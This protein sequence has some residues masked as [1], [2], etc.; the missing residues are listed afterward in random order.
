MDLKTSKLE[1]IQAILKID[2]ET[3]IEK[4]TNLLQKEQGDFWNE[5]S[6][7]QQ[8]EIK[9]GLAELDEGKRVPYNSFVKKIS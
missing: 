4:M 9:K 5:L 6:T 3:I 2:N 1:L 8:Q 7:E